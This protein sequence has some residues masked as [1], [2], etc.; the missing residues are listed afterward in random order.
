MSIETFDNGE[1]GAAIR[2]K[3]NEVIDAVNGGSLS[4]VISLSSAQLLDLANTAV[5]MIPAPGLN[6]GIIVT[7]VLST[8]NF[9]TLDYPSLT[10]VLIYGANESV[11]YNADIAP[12]LGLAESAVLNSTFEGNNFTKAIAANAAVNLK[13]VGDNDPAAG[14][15]VTTTIASG[16]SGY[17]PGDE[18][19]IIPLGSGNEASGTINTVDGG[20]AVLTY[21]VSDPGTGYSISAGLVTETG[22]AGSGFTINITAVQPGDGTG[23]IE[24]FYRIVSWS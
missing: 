18:F 6:K 8:Y 2:T 19:G 21:T 20:G 23:I 22:G 10:P 9:N 3:L 13:Y 24:V 16:G 1:T 11:S 14:P 12:F 4:R 15:I 5:E 17:A 7:E